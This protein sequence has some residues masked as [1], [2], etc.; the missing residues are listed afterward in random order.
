MLRSSSAQWLLS[1]RIASDGILLFMPMM[2]F[3]KAPR[4][5]QDTVQ[6]ARFTV[7]ELG[8]HVIVHVDFDT[9]EGAEQGCRSEPLVEHLAWGRFD[10]KGDLVGVTIR[11][12][13]NA[14]SRDHESLLSERLS[15]KLGAEDYEQLR[16]EYQ[17]FATVLSRLQAL[18]A[19][20]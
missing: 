14:D 20:A 2:H 1:L 8:E 10:E 3:Y 12:F 19:A 13:L 17:Q 6:M 7:E 15:A 9:R 11:L 18:L 4:Q 16:T 5:L